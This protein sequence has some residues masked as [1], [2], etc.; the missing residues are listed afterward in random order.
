MSPRLASDV[1]SD[2]VHRPR[3]HRLDVVARIPP[4]RVENRVTLL[5][6]NHRAST[7]H[8]LQESWNG[9]GWMHLNQEMNVGAD[10]VHF[11]DGTALLAGDRPDE[12]FEKVSDSPVDQR[13]STA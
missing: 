8:A 10:Q 13:R 3:T 11:Q 12:P 6:G 1:L 4:Q 7:L 2:A 9:C 5:G